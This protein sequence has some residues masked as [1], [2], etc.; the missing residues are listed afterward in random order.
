MNTY[1][2]KEFMDKLNFKP[3]KLELIKRKKER[4]KETTKISDQRFYLSLQPPTFLQPS[5]IELKEKQ[6]IFK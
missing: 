5:K 1:S 2:F 4:K 6:T 3:K